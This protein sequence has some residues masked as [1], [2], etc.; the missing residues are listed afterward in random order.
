MALPDIDKLSTAVDSHYARLDYWKLMKLSKRLVWH[1]NKSSVGSNRQQMF[2]ELHR[3]A[4]AMAD[5]AGLRLNGHA[6]RASTRER[7]AR[8]SR[9]FARTLRERVRRYARSS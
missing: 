9:D 8:M 3:Y 1:A 7:E 6:T 4:D 5:A 2:R